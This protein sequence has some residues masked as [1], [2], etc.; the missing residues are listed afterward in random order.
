[1][2]AAISLCACLL[3]AVSMIHAAFSTSS[4]ACS[5]SIRDSAIHSRITPCAASG[6]PN[7]V[8][9]GDAVDH[10][11]ERALAQPD[12]PH[13]VVDPARA[14]PRLRDREARALLADQVRRRHAHVLVADVGVAVLVVVAEDRQVALDRHARRVERD[15]D[16]RVLRVARPVRL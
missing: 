16:H 13:A 9:V 8:A 5:I 4:R 15:E 7:A 6:L 12:H 11:L 14:E 2:I 3:P 1:M 10:Q